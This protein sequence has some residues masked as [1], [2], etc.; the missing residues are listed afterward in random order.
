MS[1]SDQHHRAAARYIDR[2]KGIKLFFLL[3]AQAHQP[4]RKKLYPR[5][6][7]LVDHKP[8]LY[9]QNICPVGE[10]PDEEATTFN[11][12]VDTASTAT[13]CRNFLHLSGKANTFFSFTFDSDFGYGYS[14]GRHK[15]TSSTMVIMY[16]KYRNARITVNWCGV[17]RKA[18]AIKLDVRSIAF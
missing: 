18:S 10:V 6:P 11:K 1:T 4:I 12:S 5:C 2:W 15:T 9:I 13:V 17:P 16:A 7:T 3:N 14:L 8:S